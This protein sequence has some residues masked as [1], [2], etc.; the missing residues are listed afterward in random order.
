MPFIEVK[1][2]NSTT[3]RWVKD[4]DKYQEQNYQDDYQGDLTTGSASLVSLDISKEKY[5]KIF[6]RGGNDVRERGKC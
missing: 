2:G 4:I 1:N 6:K 5:E 3:Y